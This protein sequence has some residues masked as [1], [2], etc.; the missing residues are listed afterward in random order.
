MELVSIEE[1]IKRFRLVKDRKLRNELKKFAF[2]AMYSPAQVSKFYV[3]VG[4]LPPLEEAM[5]LNA[6]DLSKLL[7]I[8]RIG[9]A[10]TSVTSVTKPGLGVS[11]EQITL[12]LN[13]GT[14][15]TLGEEG[16]IVPVVVDAP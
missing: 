3:P 13:D 16:G 10:Q 9:V 8:A 6:D 15:I 7:A 12:K 14:S 1:F 4:I 2:L 11:L 5:H